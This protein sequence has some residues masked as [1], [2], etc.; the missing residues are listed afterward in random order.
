MA[1]RWNRKV[2]KGIKTAYPVIENKTELKMNKKKKRRHKMPDRV[3]AVPK[4]IWILKAL[5]FSYAITGVLLMILAFAVYRLELGERIVTI[6]IKGI[7]LMAAFAGGL[8]TGKQVKT[9]RFIWGM[10]T[11]GLYFVLLLLITVG[12]YRAFHGSTADI[13]M[14]F[15]IC[16]GGGMAGGMI[17]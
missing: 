2:I 15:G 9:R 3:K 17:S 1:D 8:T 5:L 4:I 16:A 11:G 7:Y 13:L 14:T 6:G 12:I 10:I